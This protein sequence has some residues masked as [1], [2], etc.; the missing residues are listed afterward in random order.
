MSFSTGIA[1]QVAELERRMDQAAAIATLEVW[2]SVR[3]GSAITGSQGTPVVTG[4]ARNSWSIDGVA[5]PA[6]A[7]VA[8]Q[9]RAGEVRTI[10][11][12]AVYL[13]GLEEGRAR[14]T[15]PGWVRLTI[16]QWPAVTRWALRQVGLA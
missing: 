9:T 1:R 5:G 2:N 14:R 4:F 6:G 15:P 8:F 13:R 12:G 7:A 3:S 11:G 16:A 10:R